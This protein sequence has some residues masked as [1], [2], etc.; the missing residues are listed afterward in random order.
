MM[1]N[2]ILPNALLSSQELNAFYRTWLFLNSI[3]AGLDR[4]KTPRIVGLGNNVCPGGS[5]GVSFSL[6]K[7]FIKEGKQGVLSLLSD[8]FLPRS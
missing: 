3:F 2:T 7:G 4:V 8:Q 5:Q 6:A 1:L